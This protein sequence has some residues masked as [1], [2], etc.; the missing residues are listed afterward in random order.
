MIS[1]S[2]WRGRR[3][4]VTGH[5]G[6]M[7]GWLVL[8]LHRLGAEVHGYALDPPTT[9]NLFEAAAVVAA[10][11][12][13]LRSDVRDLDRLLAAIDDVAPDTVLHLAAQ[14]LVLESYRTPA[15]T[16]AT[17]VLGTV[18]LLEGVRR[19]DCVEAAVIITS[20]KCYRNDGGGRAFSEDDPLG[21]ADPYSS[22]KACAE[23]VTAAYRESFFR[24]ETGAAIATARAGNIIGGGD[25]GA[26]R[27]VPDCVRAFGANTPVVLRHPGAIRPWQHVLDAVVGYLIL[28]E[29]MCGVDGGRYATAW[30]FGPEAKGAVAVE[31]V[32]THLMDILGG[33]VVTAEDP[34][35]PHEAAV[36]HLDN[37][38]ALKDL[39]WAQRW[40]IHQA[41]DETARW[42]AAWAADQD[43]AAFTR[44][45]IDRYIGA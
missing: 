24:Q 27:L 10:L 31:A 14:P 22:S 15:A 17:N 33:K 12:T 29:K 38:R 9:P 35:A 21:G 8:V 20:D 18:H 28:V 4:F 30:N 40:P 6:F 41:L 44:A 45:Q 42:Y 23:L 36:L 1:P 5:T 3:V 11:K 32:A 39:G 7:G 19:A 43:M 37:T 26:N 16:Y 2:F 13:D 25:W 34:D